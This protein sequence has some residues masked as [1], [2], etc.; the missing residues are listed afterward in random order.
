MKRTGIRDLFVTLVVGVSVGYLLQ[1]VLVSM[2]G[3]MV[4]PPLTFSVTLGVA[5]VA[6]LVLAWPIRAAV[7]GTA[8]TPLNPIVAGRVA[9]FAKASSLSGGLCTGFAAGLA[10]F[11]LTRAVPP[12]GL[13][14]VQFAAGVLAGCVL[15]VAGLIAERFCTLPPDDPETEVTDGA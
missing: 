15:L 5:A 14:V 9:M 10:Y 1:S 13:P 11:A 4:I 8:R 7:R 3:R 2:G 6:V 12:S